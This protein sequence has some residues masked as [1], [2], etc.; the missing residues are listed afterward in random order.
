MHNDIMGHMAVLALLASQCKSIAEF[1]VRTGNSTTAFLFGLSQ[2]DGGE[3]H[4]YDINQ[5]Q[6][7]YNPH[8]QAPTVRWN[9]TKTDTSSLDLQVPDVDLLFIDT[10]HTYKQVK[11]ELMH[12]KAVQKW[13]VL[14]D[15]ELNKLRGEMNGGGIWQA[16]EEFL[17]ENPRWKVGVHFRH[18]NGLTI[19]TKRWSTL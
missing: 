19:L 5:P 6:I 15:T 2:N 14:H 7:D 13:I 3:L 9:F 17:Q 11:A 12:A 1:G 4:S 16:V 18:N 8:Q 10:L